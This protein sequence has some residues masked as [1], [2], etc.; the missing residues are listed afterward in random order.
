ME[1]KEYKYEIKSG[2]KYKYIEEYFLT[3]CLS[4]NKNIFTFDG[5]QI[6]YKK[7]KSKKYANIEIDS[8]LLTFLGEKE[9]VEEAVRKFRMNFLSAGG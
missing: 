1:N 9:I 2:V 7:N 6:I 5:Y 3:F 4:Y 8:T